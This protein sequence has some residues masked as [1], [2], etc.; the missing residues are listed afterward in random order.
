MNL[1]KLNCSYE[2]GFNFGWSN[3]WSYFIYLLSK[4]QIIIPKKKKNTSDYFFE[5]HL[6]LLEY[7]SFKNKKRI[8]T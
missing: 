5:E 3:C 6:G 2:L 7:L 8:N 1:L 4:P